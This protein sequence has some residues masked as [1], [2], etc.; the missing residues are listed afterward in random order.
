VTGAGLNDLLSD[1]AVILLWTGL[2]VWGA[3]RGFRWD[4]SNG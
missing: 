3:V 4:S 2:G 1:I